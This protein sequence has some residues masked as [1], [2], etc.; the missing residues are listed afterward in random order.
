MLEHLFG[1]KT[2][3]K[4]LTLFIHHSEQAFFVRELTRLVETQINAVRRELENLIH[5]GFIIETSVAE[6]STKR[7]GVQRKYYKVNPTFPLLQE[8]KTLVTKA[9]V[10]ME[11]R[12]D[13]D[14]RVLGDVH[15]FAL[16]G[17][18][19]GQTGAPVDVF[20]VGNIDLD[21]TKK[22]MKKLEDELGFEIN[23]SCMTPQEF[24]YRKEITDRFLYS[25]LESP[26]NVM[27]DRIDRPETVKT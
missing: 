6:E 13:K 2:R 9:H 22:F 17:S 23:F 20:V 16:L 18:F 1:S 25:I 15:Y 24:K 8:M 7:P 19:I 12:L 11:R 10:L 3:A 14:I 5:I 4:L 27:I 26:K 21:A